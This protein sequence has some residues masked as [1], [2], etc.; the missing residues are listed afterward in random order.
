MESDEMINTN[1]PLIK[2]CN[3]CA[4]CVLNKFQD[5]I[6]EKTNSSIT[7]QDEY[8]HSCSEFEQVEQ[9]DFLFEKWQELEDVLV[10]ENKNGE[11]ILTRDWWLFKTGASQMDIWEYFDRLYCGGINELMAREN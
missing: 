11:Q 6:C 10:E 3:N 8:S 9:N 4:W 1:L 7:V 2:C 5:V